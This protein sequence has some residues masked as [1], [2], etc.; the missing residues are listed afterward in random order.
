MNCIYCN[1]DVCFVSDCYYEITTNNDVVS[2]MCESCF[3][4]KSPLMNGMKL[5]GQQITRIKC[6]NL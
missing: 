6:V 1:D 3:V 2:Y 4:E 5:N